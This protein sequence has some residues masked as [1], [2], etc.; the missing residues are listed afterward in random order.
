M[1]GAIVLIVVM[2]VMIPLLLGTSA[3]AAVVLGWSLKQEAE[4][5]HEGSELID[6]NR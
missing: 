5:T 2:L 3:L 4:T 1:A 6:L